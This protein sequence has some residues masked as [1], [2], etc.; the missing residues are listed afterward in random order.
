MR[1]LLLLGF[2]LGANIVASAQDFV[3]E[4]SRAYR[5]SSPVDIILDAD[6]GGDPDD[7]SDIAILN[8]MMSRGEVNILAV[9]GAHYS[10][11]IARCIQVIN[12]Y[13][14]HT[15]I[16]SGLV[17]N[18]PLV[19]VNYGWHI[20]RKYFYPEPFEP[21]VAPE[22]TRLYRQILSSRP[23]QSVTIVFSGQ[24]RNLMNVWNSPPDDISSL[25]G[26]GLLEKKVKRVILIAAF[27]DGQDAGEY[28]M[29]TDVEA[30]MALNYMTNSVPLTFVGIEQGNDVVI[31][32]GG[33]S[34]MHPDN[35]VRYA[36]EIFGAP[37]RPS[38]T[39]LGL[40][41]AARGDEWN[42]ENFFRS[43]RG[44]ITVRPNG[45]SY[46]VGDENSNQEHVIR[47]QPAARFI[48]ILDGL[49]LMPEF[50]MER[51]VAGK[52]RFKCY[53]I[54]NDT[55][56]IEVTSDLNTWEP[57]LTRQAASTGFMEFEENALERGARFYRITRRK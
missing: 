34:Q 9:M 12:R 54:A 43:V 18:G 23:D 1:T 4:S 44:R 53:A 10:P 49:L 3:E 40:L 22:A 42:G 48:E 20:W 57:F 39:G 24:L 32:S 29:V 25:D 37:N 26:R 15:N 28:N 46:F 45:S 6:P 21:A 47:M 55:V 36:H 16:P 35:P 52:L 11:F 13:Y 27:F 2:L 8:N 56:T 33:V 50:R 41:L 17:T 7:M 5:V 14:G 51:I 19:G 38:W 31:P 30:A